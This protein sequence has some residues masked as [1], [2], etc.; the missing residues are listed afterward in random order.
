[1]PTVNNSISS[2][3][4]FSP[5]LN[6]PEST[7][8][9][10]NPETVK[11][12]ITIRVDPRNVGLDPQGKLPPSVQISGEKLEELV[13]KHYGLD[14]SDPTQ[15]AVLNERLG[16]KNPFDGMRTG[17]TITLT[18]KNGEYVA[19][20]T[21]DR[22]LKRAIQG[23]AQEAKKGA[24]PPTTTDNGQAVAAK[25]QQAV[26]EAA[27]RR[28]EILDKIP[29]LPGVPSTGD[30]K[31]AAQAFERF[32]KVLQ[33]IEQYAKEHPPTPEMLSELVDRLQSVLDVVGIVDPT[34]LSDGA[35]AVISTA[36]G[37]YGNAAIS[38]VAAVAVYA[39]DLLK[40]G[41]LPE[42]LKAG[43]EAVELA[44]QAPKTAEQVLETLS[45]LSEELKSVPLED[46]PK[47]TKEALEGL[48]KKIDDYV[49]LETKLKDFANGQA[50]K[51]GGWINKP[52]KVGDPLPDGYY[53]ND[54]KIHRK[55]GKVDAK[56]AQLRLENGKIG[57]AET[58]RLSNKALQDS[59][60]KADWIA[61]ARA[62]NPALTNDQVKAAFAAHRSTVQLHHII[63][64]EV[65]KTHELAV[66][67]RQN[68]NYSLDRATNSI[69][70]SN[71]ANFDPK[72]DKYGHWE[73]HKNYTEAVMTKMDAAVTRLEGQYGDLSKV[74]ASVLEKEMKAIEN[75]F[76][77]KI[78]AG[79]KAGQVPVKPNG[80][81]GIAM[82]SPM[83]VGERY[84]IRV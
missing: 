3:S 39:G 68:T 16:T 8:A 83:S 75:D 23:L 5:T 33:G 64:D 37:H 81:L 46:V 20:G 57:L 27:R 74:P 79:V 24:Q 67:A 55:D 2:G 44:M 28:Q 21:I 77:Q 38:A 59:N 51:D 18:L 15:R 65:V 72:A 22:S 80:T 10:G 47:A 41:K 70:L 73:N 66:A 26:D 69:G 40:V 62:A 56:Y 7:L 58:G 25:Q 14:P 82:P 4:L 35:N 11:D 32:E 53:W 12:P 29:A 71:K 43:D 34:P 84:G 50:L 17:N 48:T 78:D 61:K 76:R 60:Y 19:S 31:E 13:F 36:R 42:L 9:I 63:P 30:V 54:G 6:S 1:M 49:E 52:A 45:K